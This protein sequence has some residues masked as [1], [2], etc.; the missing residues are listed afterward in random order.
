VSIWFGRPKPP[1]YHKGAADSQLRLALRLAKTCPMSQA[2]SHGV[3][4]ACRRSMILF[5]AWTARPASFCPTACPDRNS[6]I[7]WMKFRG[8]VL[9]TFDGREVGPLGE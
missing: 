5:K 6:F 1:V 7:G 8:R 2:S 9:L 3:N 4:V